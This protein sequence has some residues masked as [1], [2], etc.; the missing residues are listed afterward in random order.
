MKSQPKVAFIYSENDSSQVL[1][2]SNHLE[3]VGIKPWS[4]N[5]HILPGEVVRNVLHKKIRGS[6]Y[7]LTFFSQ[8]SV[9]EAG[10]IQHE[11]N[12]ATILLEE[13][14]ES[15]VVVIPVRLDDCEVPLAFQ[16]LRLCDWFA[17]NGPDS[18][19]QVLTQ[20]NGKL[21]YKRD[22]HSPVDQGPTIQTQE[23]LVNYQIVFSGRIEQ[24]DKD[25]VDA[26]LTHLREIAK[27]PILTV[28]KIRKGSVIF[29]LC[30]TQEGF[31][32]L[33]GL[34]A[35]KEIHE[36]S[37]FEILRIDLEAQSAETEAVDI[38][39]EVGVNPLVLDELSLTDWSELIPQ[40]T[41]YAIFIAKAYKWQTPHGGLPRGLEPKD[42]VFEAIESVYAGRR[43][44]DPARV[45]IKRLLKGVI[46]SQVSHLAVSKLIRLRNT[47][48]LWIVSKTINEMVNIEDLV[49]GLL[50]VVEEDQAM[51]E[52]L[53]H[54]ISG[55]TSKANSRSLSHV[56]AC[57]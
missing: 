28:R 48:T 41:I 50:K 20:P 49:D 31:R 30:G 45:S 1:E 17:E 32:V 12:L 4:K 42:L 54:L 15:D 53:P 55:R 43:N 51:N 46:K 57:S 40:L 10:D 13:T 26:I 37:G 6:D 3:A 2:V 9:I 8:Q 24:M 22:P 47:Q 38:H 56:F 14:A 5:T 27:D 18:L 21:I 36:I 29:E 23:N 19:I 44:W 33:Q 7:I 35:S 25:R 34:I 16:K 11:Y 52:V 39:R